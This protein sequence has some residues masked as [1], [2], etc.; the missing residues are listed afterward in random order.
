MDLLE[1]KML[2]NYYN[3]FD[4]DEI[5]CEVDTDGVGWKPLLAKR[6]GDLDTYLIGLLVPPSFLKKGKVFGLNVIWHYFKTV[7]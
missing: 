4:I 1:S 5:T 7:Y 2:I 6:Q 3:Y